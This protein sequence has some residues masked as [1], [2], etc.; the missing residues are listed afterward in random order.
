MRGKPNKAKDG[1]ERV[2]ST[3]IHQFATL[4]A[5]LGVSA[6]LAMFAGDGPLERAFGEIRDTIN[7]KPASG[8]IHLVEI[9]AKSLKSL[10]KWPWPRSYHAQLVDRLNEAGVDQIVFD[11][12][13]S[14]RSTDAEDAALAGALARARGK[15]VLPTFRQPASSADQNAELENLPIEILRE[16]AFLGSVNVHPGKNGQVNRYPFGAITGGV[17]RPSIGAL[18]ANANGAVTSV[19]DLDHSIEIDTIPAYSF[20]D[21][22]EGRFDAA[23]FEGKRV[24]VGATAIE[25]GDRYAT[26]RFGIVPGVLLQAL[27]AET[28]MAGTALPH[29]GPWP[30]LLLALLL[31]GIVYPFLG[32]KDWHVEPVA[33]VLVLTIFFVPLFAERYRVANL[34]LVPALSL[35]VVWILGQY[36]MNF[37]RRLDRERYFDAATGLPNLA[38]WLR[39]NGADMRAYVVVAEVANFG[40]ILSTL[41]EEDSVKFVGAVADRCKVIC[42]EDELHRIGRQQFC[43]KMDAESPEALEQQLE[44]AGQL[45]N[46]PLQVNGRSIRATLC[47]GLV[48]GPLSDPLGLSNKAVLAAQRTSEMGVRTLWHNDS[49]ADD[50]NQTLFIIS[51]FEN[52]VESGE[53]SVVYQPKFSIVSGRVTGAEALARWNSPVI[54]H[55]SPAIFVPVLERENLIELLTLFVLRRVIACLEELHAAGRA[56][57]CAVNISAPL[58]GRDAFVQAAMDIIRSGRIDASLLTFELTETAVVTSPDIVAAA[59]A[60]FADLGVHLSIDD[61]GT[62]QSTLSYLKNF[63]ASEI[64]IDQSFVRFVATSNANRIMVRSTIEMAHALGISVVAEGVEDEITFN[65]L[66]EFGCDTIQGWHIG[67]PLPKDQYIAT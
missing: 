3:R 5:A 7:S 63:S 64:K 34:D 21:I 12:D 20:V 39:R 24:I 13:F 8:E 49:L 23:D 54:G 61:Y 32:R 16:H 11:I 55:I 56:M 41:G 18:L 9:D 15:V 46:S 44:A 4:A 37:L 45:F 52:A 2:Y 14:S 47:F 28:L 19:F 62:G 33:I 57:S 50:T 27:A 26:A 36:L 51:E 38:A 30:M 58:L 53:V 60:R 66:K 31:L 10:D 65:M 25:M 59:L 22:V 17:P 40:E 1:S 48:E 35:V 43:W 42:G 6:S 29:L 67:R